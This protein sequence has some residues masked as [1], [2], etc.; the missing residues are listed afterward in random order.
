M[1]EICPYIKTTF[2]G[3]FDKN[4]DRCCIEQNVCGNHEVEELSKNVLYGVHVLF[5]LYYTIKAVK[6]QEEAC[7]G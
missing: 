3:V 4:D 1:H 6:T 7:S 2:A 5:Y